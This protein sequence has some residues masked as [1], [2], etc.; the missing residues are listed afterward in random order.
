MDDNEDNAFCVFFGMLETV[1]GESRDFEMEL[2][3]RSILHAD[4]AKFVG[5]SGDIGDGEHGDNAR[6]RVLLRGRF[7]PGLN[8][9]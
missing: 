6:D 5:L 7:P 9:G 3:F 4:G 8:T 2:N 1:H